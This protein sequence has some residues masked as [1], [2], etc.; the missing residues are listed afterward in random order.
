MIYAWIMT[1]FTGRR[2]FKLVS[3]I[4]CFCC[5]LFFNCD[6]VLHFWALSSYKGALTNSPII[7]LI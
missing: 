4:E 7:S 2:M 6:R 3:N 5:C 1:Y